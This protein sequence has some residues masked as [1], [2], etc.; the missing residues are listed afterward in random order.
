MKNRA[1]AAGLTKSDATFVDVVHTHMSGGIPA[2]F[3]Q[4]GYGTDLP[5]GHVD[6]VANRDGL[7]PGCRLKRKKRS[8][9]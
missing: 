7:Q 9:K 8:C 2:E 3:L 1:A 5:L 6:F 4:G